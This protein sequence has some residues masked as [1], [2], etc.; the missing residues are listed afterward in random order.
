MESS[1]LQPWTRL[2]TMNRRLPVT[3]VIKPA[4]RAPTGKSALQAG[5][6]W[7][8]NALEFSGPKRKPWLGSF[9]FRVG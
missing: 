1:H 5:G 7:E 2:G 4:N 8:V 9:H 3:P 6:S